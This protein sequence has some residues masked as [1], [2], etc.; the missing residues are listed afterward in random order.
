M[1]RC[2]MRFAAVFNLF[3]NEFIE[4]AI[5]A[6]GCK[7]TFS[8]KPSSLSIF[9]VAGLLTNWKHSVSGGGGM[10]LAQRGEGRKKL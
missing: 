3:T 9:R 8:T 4:I 5:V 7:L 6:C 10:Q 1:S 2:H